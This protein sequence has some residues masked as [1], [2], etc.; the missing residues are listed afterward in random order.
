MAAERQLQT[1][2]QALERLELAL[3]L[4]GTRMCDELKDEIMPDVRRLQSIEANFY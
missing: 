2:E 4:S 1:A 3:R